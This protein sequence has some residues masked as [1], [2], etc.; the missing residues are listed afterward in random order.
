[1]PEKP[2]DTQEFRNSVPLTTYQD[3]A[4]IFNNRNEE[5][6]PVKPLHWVCTSGRGGT[7]KWIPWTENSL[8]VYAAAGIAAAILACANNR[9]E[10]KIRKG[11][12]ALV[13]LAPPPYGSGILSK[14]MAERMGVHLMPPI[15]DDGSVENF[16]EKIQLGFKIALR[17]GVDFLSSLTSVMIKMGDSFAE[18]SGKMKLSPQMLHPQIFKRLLYAWITSKIGRRTI[19][20]KDLWRIKGLLAYGM[21]TSIYREKLEYYW[22]KKPLEIYAATETGTLATQAWNKKYLTFYPYCSFCE[23]IPEKELL[24]M[25]E[26]PEYQPKTMLIDELE[27][28]Q[29]YEV[30]TTGLHGIPMFRYR[31]GDLIRVVTLEDKEAGIKIPQM[32]FESRADDIIDIAGF[33]RLDEKTVWQ[34]I[35]NTGIKHEDWTARKEYEEKNAFLHVYFEAKEDIEAKDIIVLLH[36]ELKHLNKDYANLEN[37]LTIKPLRV[38]LLPA[39]SFQSYYEARQKEGAA[40]AHLKP[41]HMNASDKVI[42][43][44]L[45]SK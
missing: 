38:T 30:V 23:F 19:L 31:P 21:D 7:S 37:M 25:I 4:E 41:P 10:V 22:G 29:S 26:N 43:S 20:P 8:E 9:N 35:V 34:A 15:D 3:Y 14:A 18:S 2:K 28:D 39:G 27:P 42:S 16:A 12:R 40:L 6:L 32:L 5:A 44:L 13:N 24:K 11:A 45:E 33:T 17:N 36:R 1:M